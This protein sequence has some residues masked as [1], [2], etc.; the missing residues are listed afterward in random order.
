MSATEVHRLIDIMKS[1]NIMLLFPS[2]TCSQGY[3][4]FVSRGFAFHL[5]G[6][7]KHIHAGG[8]VVIHPAMQPCAKLI[9][10]ISE[11]LIKATISLASGPAHLFGTYA[12]HQGVERDDIRDKY[13]G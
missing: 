6:S 13:W 11:R 8:G 1:R 12:P 2:K 9:H 10:Q 7:I 3:Y 5:N 4:L